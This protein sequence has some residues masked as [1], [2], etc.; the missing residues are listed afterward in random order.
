MNLLA[1]DTA[2]SVFS[3]AL[4]TDRGVWH[5]E[6]DSGM[7]HSELLLD[8]VDMLMKKSGLVPSDLDGVLCMRGPGSFTGLRIGFA[9]AKGL[10]LSLGLPFSAFSTLECGAHAF[11][12]WPGLVVPVIDARKNAFFYALYSGGQRLCPDTEAAAPEIARSI[13]AAVSGP[14][15]NRVLLTGPGAETLYRELPGPSPFITV[16]PEFRR[17][18][19]L[20]LLEIAKNVDILNNSYVN[21]GPEYIRKSD[22]ELNL[23]T[24]KN[25]GF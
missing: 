12:V 7:R 20:F 11:S 2:A 9:A 25:F 21:A 17:G 4:G 16:N 18:N 22:A 19:A 6:T 3:A 5:F 15:E 13:N 1:I 8:T 14:R 23:R 10:A 24:S